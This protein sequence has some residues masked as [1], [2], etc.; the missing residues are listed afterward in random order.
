MGSAS[1]N[2][3][4]TQSSQPGIMTQSNDPIGSTSNGS[5]N[6]CNNSSPAMSGSLNL[7]MKKIRGKACQYKPW[8]DLF[9]LTKSSQD[10]RGLLLIN[11]ATERLQIEKCLDTIQKNIK[12]T[13]L[14]SMIERLDTITRQLGMKFTTSGLKEVLHCFISS[15]MFY[16]EVLLNQSDGHVTDVQIAHQGEPVS[17][18]ELTQ[19]LRQ[20]D[21]PEF[22]RHLEGISAIYNLN[23]DK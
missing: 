19:V 15:D 11:D 7:L 14:K 4:P 9:K 12:V 8:S 13:G 5:V 22:T 21:F 2:W 20:S 23:A 18:L 6:S 10:K 1:E 17:C 3:P 16:V